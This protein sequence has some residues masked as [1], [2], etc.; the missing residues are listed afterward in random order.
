MVIEK[1]IKMMLKKDPSDGM[2]G[3]KVYKEMLWDQL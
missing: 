3:S 2:R 1:K